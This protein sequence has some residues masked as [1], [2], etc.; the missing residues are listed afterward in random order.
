[1]G[2]DR[3]IGILTILNIVGACIALA[4]SVL[5]ARFFGTGRGLEVYF[6]AST[7]QIIVANLM[8]SGQLGEIFLPIYHRIVHADGRQAAQRAF[9]VLLNWMVLLVAGMSAGLWF[10]APLLLRMLVP[11]FTSEDRLLG[12]D[13]FRCLLPLVAVQVGLSLVQTLA[14]AERWF[15]KPEAIGVGARGVILIAIA[16]L[17]LPLGPWAMVAAVW[18]GH[19]IQLV[20]CLLMLGRMGYRHRL[21]LRQEGFSVRSVFARLFVTFGYVGATQV[22]AVALN[23]GLSIL[24]QGTYAVFKYVQRLYA[25]TNAVFLRPV[26]VVFFTHFSEALARG[27][28]NVEALARSA[29]ARCLGIAALA[30]VAI[31]VGGEPLLA[32]LWG[33]ERFGGEHLGL[34]ARLLSVFYALLLASALGLIARKTAMS[35]GMVGWQYVSASVV[36][37]VSAACAWRLIPA[38][39]VTGAAA[40]IAINAVGLAAAPL[41]ILALRRRDAFAFYSFV[42]MG[43][44]LL[45][46]GAGLAAGFAVRAAVSGHLSAVAPGG[47]AV[48]LALAALLAGCAV[49]TALAAAWVVN[50]R[51]VRQVCRRIR[52]RL[53]ARRPVEKEAA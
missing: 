6:A 21:C 44:W 14:N 38:F 40:T 30:M 46:A 9:A 35:L 31:V 17:A 36:Q 18:C 29:L 39:D 7:L 10:A 27:G 3:S 5:V 20:G 15:G 34:A 51:E 22:Y 11:G 13:M 33:G 47:T 4:N 28:R 24:P 23:A 53:G 45:A 1:V 19:L 8:Q 52:G 37:L 43:R 32:A 16:A 26:S 2:T 25:K 42:G 12:V 49:V 50:V 41:V 48:K